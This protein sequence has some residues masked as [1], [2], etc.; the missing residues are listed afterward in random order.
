MQR[1]KLPSLVLTIGLVAVFGLFGIDKFLEPVLW[2]SWIPSWM[3]GLF[4]LSASTWLQVIGGFEILCAILLLIPVTAV[5]KT[6]TILIALQILSILPIAGFNN[7]GIRD[8]CIL[9]AD[10]ALFLLL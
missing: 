6:V 8:F 3:D 9:C 1:P 2:I 7:I 5:R 10:V 4:G